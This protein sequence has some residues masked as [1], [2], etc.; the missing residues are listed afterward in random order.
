M[1]ATVDPSLVVISVPPFRQ[2]VNLAAFTVAGKVELFAL[3]APS[4][5]HTGNISITNAVAMSIQAVSA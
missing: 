3:L 2:V 5:G 4:P 1:M